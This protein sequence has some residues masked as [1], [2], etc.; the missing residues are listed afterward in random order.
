M[1]T[2]LPSGLNATEITGF[3]CPLKTRIFSPSLTSSAAFSSSAL[4]RASSSLAFLS[5]NGAMA[6]VGADGEIDLSTGG[7]GILMATRKPNVTCL[8]NMI[9]CLLK[10][11]TGC[12]ANVQLRVSKPPADHARDT[13]RRPRRIVARR[14]LVVGQI[15]PIRTPFPYVAMHVIQ[16]PWIGILLTD[17]ADYVRAFRQCQAFLSTPI[18]ESPKL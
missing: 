16:L 5:S 9:K 15:K 3:L 10:A 17:S 6:W 8:S 11:S 1:S 7:H 12:A 14:V 13:R 18:S 2:R 4:F